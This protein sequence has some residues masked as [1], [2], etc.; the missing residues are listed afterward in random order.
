MVCV[1]DPPTPHTRPNLSIYNTSQKLHMN[2]NAARFI[3]LFYIYSYNRPGI[4][5]NVCVP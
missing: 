3:E 1:E 5:F 4:L 2:D